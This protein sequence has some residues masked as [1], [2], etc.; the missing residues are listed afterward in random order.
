MGKQP[1]KMVIATKFKAPIGIQASRGIVRYK[2][3][4]PWETKTL[5]R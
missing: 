5:A 1:M 2:K 4:D 3:I